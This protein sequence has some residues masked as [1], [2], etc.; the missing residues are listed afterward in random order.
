MKRPLLLFA[1]VLCWCVPT[2]AEEPV[3]F[4]D[5]TLQSVVEEALWVEDPTPSDMLGF[6]Y[7][8]AD[9][10]GIQSLV[11]LEY[12]KNLLTLRLSDNQLIADVTPLSGLADLRTLVLNQNRIPDITP[13][14]GLVNLNEL[15][16]HHN[17]IKDISALSGMTKLRRLAL[18]ENPISDISPLAGIV[19]VQTL[20]LSCTEIS[21]IS[22]LLSM[23][24]LEHLDLRECPLA[25]S[26]YDTYIPQI[27]AN[28]LIAEIR[29]DPPKEYTV[30]MTSGDGGT[31]SY[32]GEGTFAFESGRI[33]LLVA[34]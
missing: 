9:S 8:Q 26:A 5:A 3:S 28:N 23:R 6:T 10:M 12:A 29:Y 15:D 14:A 30:E 20:I 31:V 34:N 2:T 11:G 33:I 24:S 16:L 13:L 25:S 17:Q 18:R 1:A 27:Q 4:R 32:P 21:D 22:P 7:L 19:N